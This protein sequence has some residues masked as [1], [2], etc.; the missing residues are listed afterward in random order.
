MRVYLIADLGRFPSWCV[1]VEPGLKGRTNGAGA[2]F[3]IVN[4]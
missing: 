2:E 1:Q 3:I 4:Q